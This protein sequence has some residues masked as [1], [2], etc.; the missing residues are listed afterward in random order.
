MTIGGVTL[1]PSDIGVVTILF[2]MF[3]LLVTDVLVTGKRLRKSEARATHL[4]EKVWTLMETAQVAVTAA[5]VATEVIRHLPE[6][7]ALAREDR[8][9]R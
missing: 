7:A 1:A 3:S 9:V 6:A 8:E 2:T 5:E 4:E